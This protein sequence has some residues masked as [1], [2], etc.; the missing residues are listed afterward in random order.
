M[1]YWPPPQSVLWGA[2]APLAPPPVADPM[3][4]PTLLLAKPWL[5]CVVC[6]KPITLEYSVVNDFHMVVLDQL[7]LLHRTCNLFDCSLTIKVLSIVVDLR[8]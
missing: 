7:V 1:H 3:L 4:Q 2:M 6:Y 8:L 5:C